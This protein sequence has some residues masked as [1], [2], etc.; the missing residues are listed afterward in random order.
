MVFPQKLQANDVEWQVLTAGVR[1]GLG[2]GSI[3]PN[4]D[5][6]DAHE[7][8]KSFFNQLAKDF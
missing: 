8:P 1:A 3:N 2:L 5:T 6:S 7:K 4:V